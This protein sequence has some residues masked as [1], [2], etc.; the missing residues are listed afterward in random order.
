MAAGLPVA[1]LKGFGVELEGW[2]PGAVYL[3]TLALFTWAM[4]VPW[5]RR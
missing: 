3:V 1:T 5:G 2:W 4:I